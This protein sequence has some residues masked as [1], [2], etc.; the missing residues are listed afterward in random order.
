MA[1]NDRTRAALPALSSRAALP[2]S[3]SPH[4]SLTRSVSYGYNK[5]I[6]YPEEDSTM[7]LVVIG[8]VAGGASAA[9]RVRRLDAQAEIVMLERGEHVQLLPALSPE[10]HRGRQQ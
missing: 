6:K 3:A 9:A 2:C 1:L 7:K 4:S 10:Q 8:G 5:N